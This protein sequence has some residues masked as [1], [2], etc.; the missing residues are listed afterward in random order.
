MKVPDCLHRKVKS[1]RIHANTFKSPQESLII[2]Y[3][4]AGGNEPLIFQCVL[5][6]F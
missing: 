1:S 4:N 6:E 5:D 2:Y 3:S